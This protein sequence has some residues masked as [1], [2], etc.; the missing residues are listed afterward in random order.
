MLRARTCTHSTRTA[1]RR[2]T[3]GLSLDILARL[4]LYERGLDY[5]H[6]TGHG[7][8]SCLN[9]HEGPAGISKRA[10]AM[11]PLKRGMIITNGERVH[12]ERERGLSGMG[13]ERA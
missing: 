12:V 13:W 9:V 7:V 5:R 3:P 10:S 6:G 1:R 2:L 8:G 11:V 4:P